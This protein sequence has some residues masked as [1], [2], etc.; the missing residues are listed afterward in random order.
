MN[1]WPVWQVLLPLLAAPSCM[2]IR[3]VGIVWVIATA[4]AGLGAAT[5]GMLL[6]EVV[7]NGPLSYNIGGWPVPWGIE[8][9]VDVLNAY[10]LV[11]V[12]ALAA[13]VVG[14]GHSLVTK[15][16]AEDR[17]YLLYVAFLLHISGLNGVLATGDA[18]NLFVFIEIAS[19]SSYGMIA[20]SRNSRALLSAYSYLIYGTL[21]ASF[22]LIAIGILYA[23]TGTLNMIDLSVRLPELA[24]TRAVRSALAFFTVG[25]MLKC[26]I[27]PLHIWLPGAYVWSPST[28]ACFLAGTTTKV[29]LYV[30]IRFFYGVFGT[31][32]VSPILDIAAVLLIL[33]SVGVVYGSLQAI[34]QDNLRLMLAWSSIAQIGYMVLALSAGTA[35]GVVAA[36]V[37]MFNHAIIKCALFFSVASLWYRFDTVSLK[38]LA[39]VSQQAAWPC[40]I[41]VLSGLS[42]IGLPLT[43]GF[44]SK[45][46]LFL[47]FWDHHFPVL[48]FFVVATSV[49]TAVYVWRAIET[50]YRPS[51]NRS[52]ALSATSF[53]GLGT[54]PLGLGLLALGAGNVLFGIDTDRSLDVARQAV[55]ELGI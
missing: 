15:G 26:A 3:R 36:L 10:V 4:T 53:A 1:H 43:A 9:R 46:Y 16:I 47:A 6:A 41:F 8:Y 45:W 54:L 12:N 2:L 21:G 38:R 17:R 50:L 7:E 13:V 27:F 52:A 5:A 20:A 25:I 42:L 35:E 44:I 49:L 19:L 34:R 33:A 48:A 30:L 28:V 31:M 55:S 24:D 40:A 37:H 18:F 14:C 51:D 29:F 32:P 11:I 23:M 39:G 22:I